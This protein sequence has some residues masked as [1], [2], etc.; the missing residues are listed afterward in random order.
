[1]IQVFAAFAVGLMAAGA[2]AQPDVRTVRVP[3]DG[4]QPRLAVGSDGVVHLIYLTGDA[5]SSDVN[6][7]RATGGGGGLTFGEPLRVNTYPGSA[8]AVGTIRGPHLAL[9]KNGRVHVAWMGSAKA[10]PKAPGKQAPMLYTRLGDDGRFEPERNLVTKFAGLDGGGTVAADPKGNVYVAWHAPGVPR[11]HESTRRVFIARS[12]DDGATFAPEQPVTD[13]GV[14]ACACCGMQLLAPPG[15]AVVGLFRT[16][17]DQTQ[18]DTHAF[19]FQG[20]FDRR[21]G[22]TLDPAQSA[23]CMMSTYALADVPAHHRFVAAWETLGR[24][25]FGV[26]PYRDIRVGRPRDVPGAE[27]DAKHPTVAVDRQGKFLIAW[28]EGTGWERGGSVAWQVFDRELRPVPNAAGRAD[29]L[30]AWSRPAAFAEPQGG[31]VVVY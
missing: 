27:R 16:A 9:G 10:Q 1:M 7:V 5:Q 23:T 4:V 20:A 22:G 17:T 25:R 8:L 15:G 31:F 3:H 14:G 28:A 11:G 12:S 19:L 2:F 13:E 21:W 6:Y 30:P 18:R 24:I 26:Y 29:G